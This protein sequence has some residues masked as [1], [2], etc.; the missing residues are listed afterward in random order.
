[1]S[2]L[3]RSSSTR[4]TSK[5]I[6]SSLLSSLS[7][8]AVPVTPTNMYRCRHEQDDDPF[9]SGQENRRRNRDRLNGEIDR[10]NHLRLLTSECL[11][12]P[13]R[14]PGGMYGCGPP[15]LSPILYGLGPQGPGFLPPFS[16]SLCGPCRPRPPPYLPG[17]CGT[18]PSTYFD[19]SDSDSDDEDSPSP[20]YPPHPPRYGPSPCT[21]TFSLRP[22]LVRRRSTPPS[23]GPR[24]SYGR[25]YDDC[26]DEYHH[27]PRPRYVPRRR[28]LTG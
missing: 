20:W 22:S 11:R 15:R 3:Q 12:L 9:A 19:D 27:V 2:S 13:E 21:T 5:P 23:F 14:Y 1:M 6:L 10:Y 18:H 25:Y 4:I 8:R 17:M 26:D 16:G 24:S 28:Y 7:L